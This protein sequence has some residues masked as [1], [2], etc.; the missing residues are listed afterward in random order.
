MNRTSPLLII[1]LMSMVSTLTQ[2]P[3]LQREP[4]QNAG[5]GHFKVSILRED[6]VLIPFAE[7]RDGNWY[8]PRPKQEA[9]VSSEN[10]LADLP[11]AWF[12]KDSEFSPTWYFWPSDGPPKVLNA[13]KIVKV[14]NHGPEN[15]GLACDYPGKPLQAN[16]HHKNIGIALDVE[17]KVESPL[18]LTNSSPDSKRILNFIQPTSFPYDET[19]PKAELTLSN[20]YR[21]R[22]AI[23]GQY[24]YHFRA[25]K[26]YGK[27]GSSS[28]PACNEIAI[29]KGWI[30]QNKQ[31]ELKLLDNQI[32]LTDCDM[33]IDFSFVRPLGILTVGD[34]AFIFT[35]DHGYEDES[36][37]IFEMNGSG[38]KR[39]LNIY[40]GGA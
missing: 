25:Q 13:G 19:R 15:W 20:V 38:I 34:R 26:E 6:G 2:G 3:R 14:V 10:S 35:E 4:L 30:L 24:I 32:A 21:N 36:Y 39:V 31:G 40:G 5:A 22:Y 17:K 7:Y 11:E 27:T 12:V 8:A 29:L 37:S 1:L 9:Y 23:D 28:D 33:K 16:E 18:E